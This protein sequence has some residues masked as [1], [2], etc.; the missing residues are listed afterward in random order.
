MGGT[1]MINDIGTIRTVLAP[2][3]Q[4]SPTARTGARE[5]DPSGDKVQQTV[6]PEGAAKDPENLK[7]VVSDLNK[8]VQNLQ[9]ELQFSVDDDSGETVVKVIDRETDEVVRQIPS[10]EVM[11]L[12]RRLEETSGV[13]FED[14]A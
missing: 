11:A 5:T 2:S 1:E 8:L 7:E 9:R 12:K 3:P 14:S 4:T 10:E 13:I 6:V